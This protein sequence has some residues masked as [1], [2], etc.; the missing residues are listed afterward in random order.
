M[1]IEITGV[2]SYKI[3]INKL[4]IKNVDLNDRDSITLLVKDFLKKMKNK[5][6]LRGFYKV[7][8]FPHQA[9]GVFLELIQLEELE[10]SN[11]LDLRIVVYF[12]EAF[13]FETE[14][15]F[16]ISKSSNIRFLDGKFY[17][18]I[19]DDFDELLE[20]VEFGRIIYG[21][22]VINV[23]SEGILI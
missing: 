5:L 9:I 12:D 15:Y 14:D 6:H 18:L 20:I 16:K 21:R 13:F 2:K 3:F 17:C 19:D 8:V 7:K 10:F 4:Y 23:L 11:N 22:E 1:K